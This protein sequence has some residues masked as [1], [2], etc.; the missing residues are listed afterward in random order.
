MSTWRPWGP[1]T[2]G[3]TV[4]DTLFRGEGAPNCHVA[5]GADR[6]AFVDLLLDIFS[7]GS[8]APV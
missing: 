6:Q 3:R 7:R 1:S 8:T 4:I 2:V 5:F